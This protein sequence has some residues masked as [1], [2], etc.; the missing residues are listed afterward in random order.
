MKRVNF[1]VWLSVCFSLTAMTAVAQGPLEPAGSPAPTMKSLDQ[2]EPRTPIHELP[3]MITESGSY[4]V[5]G[6]LASASHG[7]LVAASGVTIDLNGHTLS[8]SGS[9]AG[10][11]TDTNAMLV[12]RNGT[13]EGF[14]IGIGSLNSNYGRYERLT[15]RDNLAYGIVIN[16]S[17][18]RQS[19]GNV[20]RD[21]SVIGHNEVGISIA[22]KSEG[23]TRGN[24][25]LNSTV[26]DNEDG[27]LRLH[28]D[29]GR[30]T[31]T[32][33]RDN[34]FSGSTASRGVDLHSENGG[35]CNANMF[36]RNHI[37]DNA[38]SGLRILATG[39][40][41]EATGNIIEDN[42]ISRNGSSIPALTVQAS[43]GGAAN[44]NLLAGNQVTK[45]EE[46]GIFIHAFGGGTARGNLIRDSVV[47]GNAINGI[48]LDGDAAGTRVENNRVSGHT[49]GINAGTTK[50][51]VF[52][53]TLMDNGTAILAGGGN[54]VGLVVDV[55]GEYFD[56]P[57]AWANFDR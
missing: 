1:T 13:I 43:A 23:V 3:F 32:I 10:I 51:F 30:L 41:S 57:N 28:A 14:A 55:D 36:R 2:I 18:G 34:V 6:N 27:A 39:T 16:S 17:A 49:I 46:T 12:V 29:T 42:V 54:F 47:S 4:V 15:V 11:L 31:G 50:A 5:T 8:G 35:A 53:N 9:D 22:A 37:I 26:M 33:V 25:V 40:D 44:G 20:I 38:H 24:M 45:N 7:I 52:R 19:Y 56:D 21:V 48:T